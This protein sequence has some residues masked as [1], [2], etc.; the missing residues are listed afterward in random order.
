M[1]ISGRFAALAA[2]WNLLFRDHEIYIRTGGEVKFLHL[3]AQLQRRAANVAGVVLGLWLLITIGLVAWQGYASW[4]N[5][6]IASRAV[7]VEQAEAAVAA[8]TAQIG[9]SI[10]RLNARQSVI[11]NVVADHMGGDASAAA[12][13]ATAPAPAP[14]NQVSA[15][16]AINRRQNVSIAT[17]TR[18]A[19][20]RAARAE[21][22]LLTMGIRPRSGADAGQGGPLIPAAFARS[23]IVARDAALRVLTQAVMRMDEL[24]EMVLALPSNQPAEN[25]NLSSGFGY[26][27]DPFTGAASVHPGLDFAGPTGSAIRAAA[28]GV[29]SFVGQKSGYGNVVEVDHGHGIVTRYAHLSAFDSVVGQRVGPGD[30]IA[31]MGSTGRSTGPHL[32]FEVRVGGTAVN[33]RRFLEA[34]PDVLE[35]KAVAVQRNRSRVAA[36]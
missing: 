16:Q 25:V 7:A 28:R 34:N 23:P 2:K 6:D 33:P 35:V 3:S 29:I 19:T 14:K 10:Q 31:R 20:S 21:A 1:T 18:F 5:Q 32:H 9:E 26:R 27:R 22:A 4:R 24:E 8:T 30:L 36:R 12:A 17:L 15:L 11:E 13:A